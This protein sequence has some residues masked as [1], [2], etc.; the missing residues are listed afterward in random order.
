MYRVIKKKIYKGQALI[1]ILYIYE[2]VKTLEWDAAQHC[3]H[4]FV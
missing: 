1:E 2:H 4:H 3:M